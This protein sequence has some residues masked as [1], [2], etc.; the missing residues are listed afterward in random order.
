[1][2]FATHHSNY[3]QLAISG[4]GTQRDSIYLSQGGIPVARWPI[5]ISAFLWRGQDILYL[6]Q[7][8]LYFAWIVG[9]GAILDL[10]SY[11]QS[12]G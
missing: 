5:P 8:M 7:N 2:P 12:F 6:G 9:L 3:P 10:Q 4:R 1:V 11:W